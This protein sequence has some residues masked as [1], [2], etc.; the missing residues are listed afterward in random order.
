MSRKRVAVAFGTR[1]EASKMAPVIYAL[2]K[3]EGLE[4]VTFVTGQHREQLDQM[5]EIF[6]LSPD[7]DLDLMK[8]RQ[9]LPEL[10]GRMIPAA[11]AK[12]KDLKLD[13]VL[14]HGDTSTT[15][16]VA[17]AAFFEGIPVGHVEAGLRSFDM[18]QPFPE[19]AN[20]RLT[21]IL[22]DVDLPPT[23]WSKK[24]LLAEGK[25]EDRMIITG[26]TAVDAV[27]YQL[28]QAVLP[29]GIP[30][31][32]LVYITMHRREN[33]PVMAGI[34]GS[35]AD[36]AKAYTDYTFIYPV[37]LNPAVREA[38]YPAMQDVPNIRLE[39]PF[40]FLSSLA[41]QKHAELIITDSGGIQEEGTSLGKPVVVL[42]NVTER[43][44]GVEVGAIKLAG[45]DPKQV[46]DIIRDLFENPAQLGEM[47]SKPNPYGDGKAS[48]RIAQA[49]AWRLGLADKP[50]DWQLELS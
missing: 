50:A 17:L 28:G 33:L 38:V 5:L 31:E 11:A 2:S 22:T 19:E 27:H 15:F 35:L 36:I 18:Q 45:N 30:R 24:N 20:R 41:I 12:L 39:E 16:A 43:P 46:K 42:R 48:E 14:V 37:H 3:Q 23:E 32:K 21:D 44:E 40:D 29:A 10:M 25:K 26:N 49:V 4:P 8:V 1:P 7:A 6:D 47:R 34:A 9:T 13:Y